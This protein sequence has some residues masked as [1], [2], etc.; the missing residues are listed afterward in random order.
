M[1]F[2]KQAITEMTQ[3]SIFETDRLFV[4]KLHR[5]DIADFHDMQGNPLVMKF[6]K[7][8]MSLEE[9]KKELNRFISYYN[10]EGSH[11]NIWAVIEKASDQ[12]VGICGV[13]VNEKEEYE[14][15][16]RLREKYWGNGM[17]K[18][19]ATELIDYC[20]KIL[21]YEEIVAYVSEQNTGSNK[22]AK[23]LMSFENEFYSEKDKCIELA[24]RQQRDK[25]LQQEAKNNGGF[26]D[27]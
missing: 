16:Y 6:I 3:L 12:F 9:S 17:G 19:I 2:Y 7:P 20:F 26:S 1:Q 8:P 24:Y 10:K 23:Q 4:R 14:I 22:I 11:F 27:I 25:W 5:N 13:Y 21:Q 18:E 15:A